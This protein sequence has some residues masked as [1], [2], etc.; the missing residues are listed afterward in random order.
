MAKFYANLSGSYLGTTTGPLS[1]QTVAAM[2]AEPSIGPDLPGNQGWFGLGMSVYPATGLGVS[3][4]K[5]G[6]LPGNSAEVYRYGN[7]TVLAIEVN[8]DVNNSDQADNAE[9]ASDNYFTSVR[10]L[11]NNAAFGPAAIVATSGTP[12]KAP[13][14]T[15][16]A[17]P[18][19]ATVTNF[20]GQPV[21]GASVTFASPRHGKAGGTFAFGEPTTTVTT[22]ANGLAIAPPFTANGTAGSY[23]VTATVTNPTRG[24]FQTH[25]DLDNRKP[26]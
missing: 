12:Q 9:T 23:A 20:F 11:V 1:M 14:R 19:G 21:V 2:V 22:N 3:W 24:S 25:F 17:D 6:G 26:A 15:A 4:A 5:N 16:F 18:L 13:L 10:Q 7:G 8:Y